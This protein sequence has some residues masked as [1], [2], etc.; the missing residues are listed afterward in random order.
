MEGKT[1]EEL[2]LASVKKGLI[3]MLNSQDIFRVDYSNRIDVAPLIN[4][5]YRSIDQDRLTTLITDKLEEVIAEKVV[6]KMVTEMGTDIKKLLANATVRDDFRFLL[7]KTTEDIL[8]AVKDQKD[9][10]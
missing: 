4:K 10:L 5:A 2:A 9:G 7:R 6:N 8:N 1:I 3:K